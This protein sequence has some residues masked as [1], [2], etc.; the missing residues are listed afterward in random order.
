[1]SSTPQLAEHVTFRV[2]HVDDVETIAANNIAMAKASD[3]GSDCSSC[4][5]SAVAVR[6]QRV[7]DVAI[8]DCYAD[9]RH[10]R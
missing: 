10:S 5:R 7:A 1:M 9:K 6:P 4:S 8:T 3:S 2:G